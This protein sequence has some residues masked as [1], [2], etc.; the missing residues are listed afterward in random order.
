MLHGFQPPP[1][2]SADFVS[3]AISKI[4]MA[5]EAIFGSKASDLSFQELHCATYNMVIQRQGETLYKAVCSSFKEHARAAALRL[6]CCLDTQL[7]SIY[8]DSWR[9][10]SIAL[11]IIC[12]FLMYM[13]HNYCTVLKKP[14]LHRVGIDAFLEVASEPHLRERVTSALLSHVSTFRSGAICDLEQLRVSVMVLLQM[15]RDGASNQ[16][17]C[18]FETPF[19]QSS[20]AYYATEAA[21]LLQVCS[22]VEYARAVE[23]A[24]AREQILCSNNLAPT[25]FARVLK[26]MERTMIEQQA[27]QVL[28]APNNGLDSC[29]NGD[30]TE[31]LT[32]IFK[33]VSRTDSGMAALIQAFKRHSEAACKGIVAS[34]TMSAPVVFVQQA[35]SLCKRFRGIVDSCFGSRREL[36]DA[37]VSAMTAVC[38]SK[39]GVPEALSLYLDKC[40]RNPIHADGSA[41]SVVERV[42]QLFRYVS[43]KDVFQS[44]Y[45]AHMAQR[46]LAAKG[47]NEEYERVIIESLKKHCGLGYTHKM[48]R[49]FKDAEDSQVIFQDWTDSIQNPPLSMQAPASVLVLT[50][51]VW[52]PLAESNLKLP[53]PF[54]SACDNFASWYT[55]K[56]GKQRILQWRCHLASAELKCTFGSRVYVI[57]MPLPCTAIMLQFA[58][59]SGPL[60]LKQLVDATGMNDSAILPFLDALTSANHPLLLADSG[61]WFVNQD[62]SSKLLRFSLQTAS[63]ASIIDDDSLR[64]TK[65]KVVVCR[66]QLLDAAIVRIVKSRKVIGH[67]A[68]V[69]EV[70]AQLSTFFEPRPSDIKKVLSSN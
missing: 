45:V 2:P 15:V 55:S 35:L 39:P 59:D 16:Y 27:V 49:M 24:I 56:F 69:Q 58:E 6:E 3:S 47:Y 53:P 22:G 41:S 10:H 23:A 68:L 17:E 13:D 33:C 34:A 18:V 19:L 48:E 9:S 28:Q 62:F 64:G 43:D 26:E 40:V 38:N 31:A 44:F 1:P 70:C 25:T 37:F 63:V 11:H 4:I 42:M 12:S 36:H 67:S 60:N 20:S 51:G 57:T 30:S 21:R 29:L 54:Q 7:L 65:A 50:A 32:D 61:T 52:P 14:S 5:I 66:D 46:I 8:I